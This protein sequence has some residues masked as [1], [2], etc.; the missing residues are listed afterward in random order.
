MTAGTVL[1]ELLRVNLVASLVIV[2][3]LAVRPFVLRWCGARAMYWCWLVVPIAAG[4]SVVPAREQIVVIQ[5]TAS[6]VVSDERSLAVEDS[7][8]TPGNA[9]GRM[10]ETSL[11]SSI[12]LAD[13]LVA[14]WLL[15]AAALLARSIVSMRR[16]TA[17]PSVGPALVG[18]FRP[19]LVLPRDFYARFDPE[20]RALILMHEEVHRTSGHTVVNA[21]IEIARCSCWFNPI[22]HIAAIRVRTDQELACDAAVIASRPSARRAYGRALLK[23]QTAP[24]VLRLGCTWAS[25]S[26]RR[27]GERIEM[28][29]RPSLARRGAVVAAFGVTAAGLALGYT[30]WAQR[31]DRLVTETASPEAVWTPSAQAPEGT[32]THQREAQRHDHFIELAKAGDI[33]L[34]FFGTTEAEMWSWAQRGRSVWDQAF[35]SLKAANFGSQG[36]QPGSLLWRMRNG[37]LDGYTAKLVI[38]QAGTN[39]DLGDNRRGYGEGY[40]A[41]IDEIRVRQPQ[42]KILLLAALPRGRSRDEWSE[43]AQVNASE[44]AE[45]VDNQTVFYSDIGERFFLPDGSFKR[46]TWSGGTATA[47][48]EIWAEE[49]QPWIDR[50]VR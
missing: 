2:L 38:L 44:F 32:L 6:I 45:Y 35:G 42:A 48:F 33:D 14:V 17:D 1:A 15:G 12:G 5:P 9:S 39:G 8:M 22:A 36:T 50:F 49:L 24:A 23:T 3:V 7:Q 27:L 29:G 47:A 28:L 11:V 18:V 37:E 13:V 26:R 40:A 20:E 19:R 34:V 21:L 41:L 4:A 43:R 25:R 46:E 31:P 30:A 16:L 10:L